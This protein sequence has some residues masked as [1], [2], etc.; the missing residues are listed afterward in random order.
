M[1]Y[2]KRNKEE[3]W[4]FNNALEEY[5]KN[6]GDSFDKG[7]TAMAEDLEHYKSTRKGKAWK[8]AWKVSV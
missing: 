8:K 7:L 1:S 6:N 5:I 3:F 4:V 2:L